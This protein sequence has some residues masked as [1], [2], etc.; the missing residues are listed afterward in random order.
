LTD[1]SNEFFT[2]NPPPPPPFS[3]RA[4]NAM[5]LPDAAVA[6]A[7]HGWRVI[8]LAPLDKRPHPDF[9]KGWPTLAS[10]DPEVVETWWT[11][12]P[13]ANIGICPDRS[14][15]TTLDLDN[16]DGE[17]SGVDLF[18]GLHENAGGPAAATPNRGIHRVF[19]RDERDRN[20]SPRKGGFDVLVASRQFV[21]SP[22]RIINSA[23]VEVQYRWTDEGEPPEMPEALRAKIEE[24]ADKSMTT[25]E[26]DPSQAPAAPAPGHAI[27][28]S[29]EIKTS[30]RSE[31]CFQ[32]ARDLYRHD[33]SV[34]DA[35]VLA[36]CWVVPDF[37]QAAMDRRGSI[38][39]ALEW[40]WRYCVYPASGSRVLFPESDGYDPRQAAT[41]PWDT[42]VGSDAADLGDIKSLSDQMKEFAD[43][44]EF[45]IPNWLPK[46]VL[47]TLFGVDGSGKTVFI[48]RLATQLAAGR[49]VMGRPAGPP[50]KSLLLM[51][52][53]IAPAIMDRQRR[54]CTELRIHAK[55]LDPHLVIPSN[56][57][58][59]D[60][61]LLEYDRQNSHK[62]TPFAI[63]I[64]NYLSTHPDVEM[65]M[66]DP[67]SDIFAD[68]E[69]V[70]QRVSVFM[71]T[72]NRIAEKYNIAMLLLGHPAKSTGSEY[73][74]SGAWSS[75]SRS[76]WLMEKTKD[77]P[78]SPV[79]LMH[80][81]SSYGP[82]AETLTLV[83]SEH[84]TLKDLA[85]GDTAEMKRQELEI[86]QK[87]VIEFVIEA[88]AFGE[89][90]F[91]MQP[92]S[93]AMYLPA[94]MLA[95]NA[96]PGYEEDAIVS[97][98]QLI[99]KQQLGLNINT[100]FD[101]EEP[102]LPAKYRSNRTAFIGVWPLPKY[103]PSIVADYVETPVDTPSY[104]EVNE[105]G[106]SGADV[107]KHKK[108]GEYTW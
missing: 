27:A 88:W 71:R 48:Q 37:Q 82:Q 73:S 25:G 96:A 9:R 102:G 103:R 31:G 22:S 78:K 100:T 69:N 44:P 108:R 21:A 42:A 38:D 15:I 79:K 1:N 104:A 81:K 40:M 8:P 5:S 63:W 57:T 92:T 95:R 16:K 60:V 2:G 98:L 24:L 62:L 85:P 20:R 105:R 3:L 39:R 86:L 7:A 51:T 55:T 33:P 36:T 43:P 59:I 97:G 45:V 101:G 32:L 6:Y 14:G 35:D 66:L 10:N 46:G 54:I 26:M 80:R 47:T 91:H 34:K 107:D 23:G 28:H 89:E 72:L 19:K 53:D 29:H 75:K 49:P 50:V 17:V 67:I 99:H 18:K 94:V 58:Q 90:V 93:K 30:D 61:K 52:E 84:G 70:R 12:H 106:V 68:E 11:Q 41:S 74:G 56:L 13:D 76:R 4:I 65:V 64:E 77:A 87:I 83:W